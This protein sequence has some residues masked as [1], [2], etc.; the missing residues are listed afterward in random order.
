[1]AIFK[2][3]TI[4]VAKFLIGKTLVKFNSHGLAIGGIITETEAYLSQNDEASHSY[5]GQTKRNSAMFAPAATIYVYKSYGVHHCMNI[6]TEAEG[7][8]AAVLLRSIMPK[9]GIDLM[10]ANRATDNLKRLSV[11][12]GNL[13]KSLGINIED[14]L[15]V[16]NRSDIFIYDEG[17]SL[18]YKATK[19]IGISRSVDLLLRFVAV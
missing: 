15:K 12:P 11:G 10:Q 18:D 5:V 17:I 1:M 13:T 19:R 14:N 16:L 2:K 3:D 8:G 4:E 9:Y 7:V 6:V